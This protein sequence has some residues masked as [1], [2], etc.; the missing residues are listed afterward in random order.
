MNHNHYKEPKEK[1]IPRNTEK[2]YIVYHTSSELITVQFIKWNDNKIQKARFT[3]HA[4]STIRN[5][6]KAEI[7]P[8][9]PDMPGY[10][11]SLH[12]LHLASPPPPPKKKY[13]LDIDNLEIKTG[14]D[15]IFA[16]IRYLKDEE[17]DSKWTCH[18]FEDAGGVPEVKKGNILV[19]Q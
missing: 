9:S 7:C 14:Q 1:L 12:S 4:S 11:L 15:L 8:P 16:Y 13:E 2:E 19:G 18:H 5:L 10:R 6:H 17:Y 3:I